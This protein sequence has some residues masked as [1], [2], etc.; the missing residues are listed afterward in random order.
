[1]T[2]VKKVQ[3]TLHLV[4]MPGKS[5]EEILDEIKP[6]PLE[7]GDYLHSR[8]DEDDGLRYYIDN[9]HQRVFRMVL[10]EHSYGSDDTIKDIFTV[11]NPTFNLSIPLIGEK[12]DFSVVMKTDEYPEEFLDYYFKYFK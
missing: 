7:Y 5:F 11:S 1:M 12:Y 6:E 4:K 8:L 10:K 3:I 9:K 2:G